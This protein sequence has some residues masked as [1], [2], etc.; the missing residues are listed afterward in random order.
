MGDRRMA[1][2]KTQ[3]GSL[4]FYTHSTGFSLPNDAQQALK[5]AE[6]RKGDDSYALRIIVD[7][8]IKSAG[9]RDSSLNSGLMFSP[10]AEDEYGGNPHSVVIDMIKWKVSIIGGR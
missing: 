7:Q 3:D 10:N 2:I 6:G 5:T 9:S 8:L 4:Y 1:E